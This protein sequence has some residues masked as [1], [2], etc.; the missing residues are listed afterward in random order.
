MT[1]CLSVFIPINYLAILSSIAIAGGLYFFF[2]GFRLLARKRL[3][4]TT[5]TSK[6]RSAAL[7]LVE[8]NGVADGPYTISAPITGKPCFLYHTTAWE[9]RAGKKLIG[10]INRTFLEDG[11]TDVEKGNHH[12]RWA[13][14][15]SCGSRT[16]VG[17]V[18]G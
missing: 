17:A 13:S 12:R 11:N 8:V 1:V 15:S 2:A 3:L 14:R 10:M 18:G 6:I 7:G 5:P 4:L 9:Q 16:K